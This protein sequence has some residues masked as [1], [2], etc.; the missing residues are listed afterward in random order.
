[1]A[2]KPRT[3]VHF[4][5]MK[6]RGWRNKAKSAARRQYRT[7]YPHVRM[8]R[9]SPYDARFDVIA[10]W[11]PGCHR[12]EV[13]QTTDGW[14]RA[15]GRPTMKITHAPEPRPEPAFS[16]KFEIANGMRDELWN[17]LTGRERDALVQGR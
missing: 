17:M 4:P 14:G 6:V 2:Q 3:P 10:A 7:V 9:T 11:E 15:I 16:M 8:T 1:M 12:L 5:R 13:D